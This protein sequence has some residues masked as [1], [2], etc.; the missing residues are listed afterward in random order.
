MIDPLTAFSAVATASGAI[1]SAI[2]AG[3]D[4]ASLHG[5]MTKY[6]RAE[7]ELSFGSQRKKNSLLAKF[8]GAEASAIDKYFKKQEVDEARDKLRETFLLYAENG[9]SKWLAL[10]KMIAEERVEY[11]KELA[12]RAEFRDLILNILGV[13]VLLIVFI[14]GALG[15]FVLA[16]YLKEQQA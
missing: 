1:S 16:K 15:V 3:K 11:K 13:I 14:A 6:A 4:I 7:A 2:K 10:N 8:T 12:R 5:P 9:H